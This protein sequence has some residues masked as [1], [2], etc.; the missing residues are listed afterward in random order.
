MGSYT[1]QRTN[2]GA[3]YREALSLYRTQSN[4]VP[5]QVAGVLTHLRNLERR[6]GETYGVELRGRDVLDI[7]VGQF[8]VQ[9]QYFAKHNRAV[10][11]D[12]D[13][14]AQ[15]LNPLPYLE[16]FRSNG[17]RRTAKT[18]G[19]KLLGID[20]LYAGELR[21]QLEVATLPAHRILRMDA[22]K[23]S[24]PEA[25]FDFVHCQ[26]VFHHLPTPAQAIAEIKR[27]LRPGGVS[28]VSFHLY[29]SETGSL[30]PRVFTE[31]R[32][33][34]ALWRH[35]R[36]QHAHELT[37][38]AYLNKLRLPEWRRLF[39]AGMPGAEIILN[40]SKRAGTAEDARR[41]IASGEL[42]DYDLEELATHNVWALWRKPFAGETSLPESVP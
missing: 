36:P 15:G 34:V 40:P 29:T 35:L 20:R 26:S 17:W 7:G 10:G 23:M 18:V 21:R 9:M 16:M 37:S 41:L 5:E 24:F 30:D 19:R 12:F 25:S 14:I 22:C 33:E 8:L 42:A 2:V 11:I 4:N 13:V 1:S 27:V 3:L 32:N 6:V 38:N 31:R 28:F 39:N